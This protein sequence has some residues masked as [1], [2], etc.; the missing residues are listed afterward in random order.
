[1]LVP[2]VVGFG[3]KPWSL[4]A[5]GREILADCT[6]GNGRHLV[7]ADR[8]GR[9]RLFVKEADRP[10]DL[11]CLI[12]PDIWQ[13]LRMAA[14]S[15]FLSQRGTKSYSLARRSL[16]PSASL[17]H[18]LIVMLKVLDCISETDGHAPSIR[19]IALRVV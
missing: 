4:L 13:E 2:T 19:E 7:V 16:H 11:A 3:G 18:R 6:D 17:A 10:I 12:R 9:H 1:M 15:A 14:L 8:A 5:E